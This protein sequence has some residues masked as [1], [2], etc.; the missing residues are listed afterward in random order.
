MGPK[1]GEHHTNVTLRVGP[2]T[3]VTQRAF[4][5]WSPCLVEGRGSRETNGTLEI[6]ADGSTFSLDRK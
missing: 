5:G 2:D 3:V 1:T 6:E 4:R